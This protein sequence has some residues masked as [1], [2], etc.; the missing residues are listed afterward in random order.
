MFGIV[1]HP[2]C[3]GLVY[4]FLNPPGPK[5]SR[6]LLVA[7]TVSATGHSRIDRGMGSC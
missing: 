5:M 4:V 2:L 7:G 3:V 1:T 6:Y